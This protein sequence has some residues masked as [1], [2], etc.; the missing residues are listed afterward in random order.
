MPASDVFPGIPFVESPLFEAELDR[1]GLN[2]AEREVAV[3][4]HHHGYAVIDFPDPHR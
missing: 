1:S 4:L 3:H 2:P